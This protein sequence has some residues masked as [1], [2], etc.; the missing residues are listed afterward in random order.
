M[1]DPCSSFHP[2]RA[3]R[4]RE[5]SLLIVN[6]WDEKHHPIL[7]QHWPGLTKAHVRLLMA[8]VEEV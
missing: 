6:A 3:N 4:L 1:M 8:E 7:A 5:L 2:N